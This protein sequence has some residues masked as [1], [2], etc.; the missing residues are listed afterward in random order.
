MYNIVFLYHEILHSHVPIMNNHHLL[1]GTLCSGGQR[2]FVSI[3]SFGHQRISN[4]TNVESTVPDVRY[5]RAIL[6][7]AWDLGRGSRMLLQ[8]MYYHTKI[9]CDDK[10]ITYYDNV[11]FLMQSWVASR[12]RYS[13]YYNRTLHSS[14]VPGSAVKCCHMSS[15][16]KCPYRDFEKAGWHLGSSSAS[17]QL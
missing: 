1:N 14:V 7:S 12:T 4:Y 16:L 13:T 15:P 9:S 17:C 5:P 6:T 3:I 2:K 8:I 11:L 10:G